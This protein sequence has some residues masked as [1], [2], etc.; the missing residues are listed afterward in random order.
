MILWPATQK[1]EGSGRIWSETGKNGR[2]HE[3]AGARCRAGPRMAQQQTLLWRA[4]CSVMFVHHSSLGRVAAKWRRTSPVVNPFAV[5]DN[6]ISSILVRQKLPLVSRGR[7]DL[8]RADLGEH[9][10]GP[11]IEQPVAADQLDYEPYL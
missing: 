7:L 8:D 10:L 4:G 1:S 11:L 5:T 9:G 3:F 2:F 6:T